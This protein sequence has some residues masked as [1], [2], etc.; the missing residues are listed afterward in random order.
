MRL[1]SLIFLPV[2]LIIG[3]GY[4]LSQPRW[5]FSLAMRVYP[6]AL[7]RIEHEPAEH[8]AAKRPAQRQPDA[9]PTVALTIDDGPG[10]NTDKILT[11]L[12]RHQ[13]R[14]TFFNLSEH[15][16]GY[17]AT[18]RRAVQEGHELGNHLTADE[19]SALLSETEFEKDLVAAEAALLPFLKPN[20]G[21]RWLR[22]GMGVY[23][24]SMVTIAQRYNYRLALGSNFPYDTHIAS[25]RFAR[26]FI[27]SKVRPGDI[28]VLHDGQGENAAR[29]DR[30]LETLKTVLP[31]LKNRGYKVTTLSELATTVEP[32][33]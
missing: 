3:S 25:S 12:N 30:T 16:P 15:L 28:I 13:A 21:L 29:G 4:L 2:L 19:P 33:N 20:Q 17:E 6:G 32:K 14:A 10:P 22:P 26:S 31:I 7:Y 18:V 9:A 24:P 8:R 23:T 5:L 27:L 1:R 11:L